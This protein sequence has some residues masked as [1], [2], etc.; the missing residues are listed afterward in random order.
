MGR[1]DD[2]LVEQLRTA[3]GADAAVSDIG[4]Q[5][6]RQSLIDRGESC[7][8]IDVLEFGRAAC[9]AELVPEDDLRAGDLDVEREFVERRRGFLLLRL[10]QVGDIQDARG[11]ALNEDPRL[12]DVRPHVYLSA[13]ARHDA[14]DV[15]TNVDLLDTEQVVLGEAL[16][17]SD[18]QIADFDAAEEVEVGGADGHLAIERGAGL[19]AYQVFHPLFGEEHPN[20]ERGEQ[21]HDD[22]RCEQIED[23]FPQT[24]PTRPRQRLSAHMVFFVH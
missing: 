16:L 5:P 20:P 4:R 11:V 24:P 19:G 1:V 15:D 6:V 22:E 9:A 2:A 12:R 18:P 8:E 10:Q 17:V 13:E 23:D 7:L 3:L 21:N 14:P